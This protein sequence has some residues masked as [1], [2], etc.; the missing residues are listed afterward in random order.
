ML[1][2]MIEAENNNVKAYSVYPGV[3][4]TE[5]QLKIRNTET[6]KFPL[7]G[8]F[9]EYYNNNELV[10]PKVIAQKIAYLMN[11]LPKFDSNMVSLR[12]LVI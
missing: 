8:R 2:R 1:T 3:V 11:N 12:D 4:D 9:I 10:H 5:M 6:T 7:R